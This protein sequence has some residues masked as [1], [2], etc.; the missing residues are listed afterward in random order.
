MGKLLV[1]LGLTPGDKLNVN[2]L[3]PKPTSPSRG[4]NQPHS[5]LLCHLF[6][7]PID[8]TVTQTAV[9]CS[10]KS[11]F[12]GCFS[13]VFTPFASNLADLFIAKKCRET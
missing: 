8:A 6:S 7:K 1:V 12:G 2:V 9:P 4:K 3:F 10:A 11:C 5:E 13:C